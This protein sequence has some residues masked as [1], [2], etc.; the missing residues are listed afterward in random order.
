MSRNIRRIGKWTL[1]RMSES[2]IDINV[3]L[4]HKNSQSVIRYEDGKLAYDYPEQIPWNVQVR[5]H[6]MF[7]R[8]YRPDAI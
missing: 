4:I 6:Q 8:K 1:T 3:N 7:K 5:I 2:S